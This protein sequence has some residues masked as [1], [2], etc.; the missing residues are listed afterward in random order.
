MRVFGSVFL[1]WRRTSVVTLSIILKYILKLDL[2]WNI[3]QQ[4]NWEQMP[5]WVC[6]WLFVKLVQQR[7]MSPCIVT[8]LT[9]QETLKSSCPCRWGSVFQITYSSFL[10]SLLHYSV[11]PSVL[12]EQLWFLSPLSPQGLQCDQRW[13]S[14]RQQACHAGVHD[15]AH[16]CEHFQGGHAHWSRG[17]PQSQKRH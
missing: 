2:K 15:P 3:F 13:L 12:R 11:P 16:W 5:S 9:L 8:L 6:P 14:R 10:L 7:K 1:S 4:P 17:L